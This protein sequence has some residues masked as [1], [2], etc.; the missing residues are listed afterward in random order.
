ML[1]KKEGR[2]KPG[3]VWGMERRLKTDLSLGGENAKA[4][5]NRGWGEVESA[6]GGSDS[7]NG[8]PLMTTT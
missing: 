6:F 5:S 2:T 4:K 3:P 1:A 7:I 8:E